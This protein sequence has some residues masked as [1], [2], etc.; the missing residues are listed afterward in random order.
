MGAQ[1]GQITVEGWCILTPEV[2]PPGG[3]YLEACAAFG[4]EPTKAGWGLLLCVDNGQRRVAYTDDIEYVRGIAELVDSSFE[5][6]V[7][8]PAG[9]LF[10]ARDGWP[11][12]WLQRWGW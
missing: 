1:D 12:E 5:G 8:I 11:D 2:W 4:V 3:S 10:A 6:D 9:K 7:T